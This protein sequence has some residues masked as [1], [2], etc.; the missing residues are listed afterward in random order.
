MSESEI[1]NAI[2]KAAR[3]LGWSV[4][5]FS[6][7]RKERR[8][9]RAVPDL[10][11]ASEGQQRRVWI[12]CKDTGKKA[13]DDQQEWLDTVNESGGEAYCCD[14]LDSALAILQRSQQ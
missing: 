12:E 2:V 5:V 9:V 10:Y 7:D 6:S 14:S 13:R 1:Q 3:Q 11:L 8:S 4:T